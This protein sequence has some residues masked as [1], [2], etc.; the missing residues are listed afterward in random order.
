MQ[1]LNRLKYRSQD[2]ISNLVARG[3]EQP[4]EVKTWGV[5]AA[6][7]FAGALAI[8]AVAKGTLAVVATLA[9]PPVALTIGAL[10]GGALG[11]SF[12]QK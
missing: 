9:N 5:T 2:A 8:T 4:K 6:A 11:W 10:G 3:K 7:G 12:M 1:N